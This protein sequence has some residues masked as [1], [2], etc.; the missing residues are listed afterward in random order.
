MTGASSGIGYELAKRFASHGLD[1]VLA[2]EDDAVHAVAREYGPHG[3][4]AHAVQADLATR[5]GS[6]SCCGRWTRWGGRSL[7][8][9]S[10]PAWGSAAGSTRPTSTTTCG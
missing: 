1:V 9:R 7:P 8:R 6:R 10:T 5:S 4:T 2:A 3:V